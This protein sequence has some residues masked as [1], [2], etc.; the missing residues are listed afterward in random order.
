MRVLP[1]KALRV[2][3]RRNLV[4]VLRG[5]IAGLTKLFVRRPQH[6]HCSGV[7][8]SGSKVNNA[9]RCRIKAAFRDAVAGEGLF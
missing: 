5:G 3:A 2:D 8:G 6:R 7:F 1:L 9:A 4:A